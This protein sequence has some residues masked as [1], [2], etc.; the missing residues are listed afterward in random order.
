MRKLQLFLI[1]CLMFV[2]PWGN[3]DHVFYIQDLSIGISSILM[4]S[5]I[6]TSFVQPEILSI[7]RKKSNLYILLFFFASMLGSINTSFPLRTFMMTAFGFSFYLAS[8][9]IQLVRPSEEEV[10]NLMSIAVLTFTIVTLMSILDFYGR[11]LLQDF[12][13]ISRRVSVLDTSLLE[14]TGSM[15]GPYRSRTEF[16]TYSILVLGLLIGY[17]EIPLKISLKNVA[18]LTCFLIILYGT[19]LA[20]SRG[21][22]LALFF[23]LGIKAVSF[24]KTA[25]FLVFILLLSTGYGLILYFKPVALTRLILGL[26]TITPGAIF[27]HTGDSARLVVWQQVM[28]NF[29]SSP[30]GHGASH[31]VLRSGESIQTHNFFFGILHGAGWF[32]LPAFFFFLKLLNPITI[33]KTHYYKPVYFSIGAYMVWMLTHSQSA[34]LFWLLTSVIIMHEE[35]KRYLKR[36]HP[37]YPSPQGLT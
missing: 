14:E 5:L 17:F 28:R 26:Q 3:A 16:S 29:F 4:L 20:G 22:Y 8:L 27:E 12:N 34:N 6:F 35:D 24:K 30:F 18:G 32:G 37:R 25:Y 15:S 13:A 10:K 11:I 2:F 9:S 33:L 23:V 36:F 21:A 7:L 19:V 1:T 31:V